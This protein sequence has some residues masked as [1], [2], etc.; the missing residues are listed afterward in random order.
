[1]K[2]PERWIKLNNEPVCFGSSGDSPGEFQTVSS[3]DASE[4]KISHV[5]GGQEGCSMRWGC[6]YYIPTYITNTEKYKIAPDHSNSYFSFFPYNQDSPFFRISIN[7]PW[8]IK[9]SETLNVWSRDDYYDNYE[10]DPP[11]ETC[12]DVYAWGKFISCFFKS[13]LL[14]YQTEQC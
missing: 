11:F 14:P 9:H 4:F 6:D 13:S 3:V 2:E 1:M 5:S 12:V 8:Y 10:P 7:N